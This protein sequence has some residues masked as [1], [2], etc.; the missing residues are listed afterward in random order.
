MSWKQMFARKSLDTLLA[1]MAGEH[2]LKRVLGPISLTALGVGAIVGSGIFVMTGRAAMQDAGP[3]IIVSYCVAALGCALA[4]FCYAEFASLAP[5]AGSAYTYA[6]ATL[7]ELL[8]WIIGWDLILEY[9]MSCATVAS[10][11]SNYLNALLEIFGWKIPGYLTSD[12]FT[13]TGGGFAINLPAVFIMAV[14]TVILVI[15]IRESAIA[16]AILTCIKLGVVLFVI[17]VG[18]GY[19][20][21]DNW[22]KIPMIQR[23]TPVETY[24]IP[25][26]VK[27]V[28]ER[29]DLGQEEQEK[30]VSEVKTMVSAAY[31]LEHIPVEARR[32]QEIGKLT[33]AEA[34]EEIEQ[35]RL[36]YEPQ[37]PKDA[38][39]KKL[40][41]EVLVEVR[42]KAPETLTDKWGML[43]YFG[44]NNWLTSIDDRVRSNFM[45]FGLSGLMLG[46][47]IVFFAFIGFDS[48]STHS[49]EAIR[50]QRDVPFGIIASLVICTVL[51]LSVSAII[52]GMVPYP[53]IDAKAAIAVAFKDKSPIS[54][55]LISIGALA[56]MTSV[57]LITFLSQARVFLAMAR[58]HLLPPGIFGA[59]H[60]KFQT[61]HIST[62]LTGVIICLVAAITPIHKL[63]EMVNIGTLFAFVVVCAA[64]LILRVTRPNVVRPFRT[65]LLYVV[66]PLGIAVNALMMLFLPI[67]TWLRLVIWLALGLVIYFGYGMRRSSLGRQLQAEIREHGL[68]GS[69]AP[70]QT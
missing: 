31:R 1:E 16:N 8:A 49:E 22:T 17:V 30:R 67:G 23:R 52:T 27:E 44:I 63:E 29:E 62:I 19:V 18:Y 48:I 28:V 46:A 60:P 51:Y 47:S 6:Y 2:R 12:P 56:G 43:G 61:P 13:Y 36:K 15:G 68:T 37:L 34:D 70:L 55:L 40:V 58:D 4:A 65:P 64:V 14:V 35:N 50:P 41:E 11:W 45:P 10:A 5:V 42:T 33:Q 59:I 54:S 25:E 39:H 26:I 53:E 66:A 69:D 38:L 24:V 7:G 3:A 21:S 57:L 9:A 20:N 32:L